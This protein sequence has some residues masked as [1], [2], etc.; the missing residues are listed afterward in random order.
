MTGLRVDDAPPPPAR[1][2]GP[3]LLLLLIASGLALLWLGTLS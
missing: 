3:L 2:L 1:D